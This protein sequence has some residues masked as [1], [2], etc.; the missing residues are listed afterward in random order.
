MKEFLFKAKAMFNGIPNSSK[1]I[2]SHNVKGG[3]SGSIFVGGVQCYFKSFGMYTGL[4][5]IN[6]K[7]FEG[8]ILEWLS[9]EELKTK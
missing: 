6:E 8:D 7:I 3:F 4:P 2:E 9:T 1:W 5:A